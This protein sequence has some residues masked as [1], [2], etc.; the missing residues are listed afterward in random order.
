MSVSRLSKQSIQS[1]FPKQQ[2]IWDQTTA[3]SAMDAISFV[4]VPSGNSATIEFNNI[5]QNYSH[6]QLRISGRTAGAYTGDSNTY[7]YL[8]NVEAGY[9][10]QLY[11]SGSGTGSTASASSL[12]SVR[13]PNN[14]NT[15][16][17]FGVGIMDILDYSSSAKTKVVR[18]FDGWDANGSGYIYVHSVL[19]N[20][21]PAVT[22]IRLTTQDG[23]WKTDSQISLYGI[24]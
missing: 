10:H 18:T 16:D 17:V 2:T 22:S 13:I 12:V 9:S 24:K 21:T 4:I 11:G 19:W 7:L 1:G 23:V 15:A 8:N 6:L 20:A 3:V 14:N 5:P